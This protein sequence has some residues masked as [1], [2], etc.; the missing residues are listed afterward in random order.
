M[1]IEEIIK[2]E[3]VPVGCGRIVTASMEKQGKAVQMEHYLCDELWNRGDKKIPQIK[4]V[5]EKAEI[6]GE[7]AVG[8]VEEKT[9]KTEEKEIA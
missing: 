9:E 7:K 2:T 3:F 5:V 8:E 1:D 6:S 4:K